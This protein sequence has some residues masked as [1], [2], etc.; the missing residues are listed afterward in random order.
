V[1]GALADSVQEVLD[2]DPSEIEPPPKI[3]TRLKT[4]FIKGM[5]KQ[6]ERFIILLDVDRVFSEEELTLVQGAGTSEV[7]SAS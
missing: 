4:E 7:S 1:L 6:G 3:G 2:L 5:G